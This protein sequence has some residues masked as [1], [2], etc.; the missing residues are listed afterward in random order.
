MNVEMH[1]RIEVIGKESPHLAT[2]EALWRANASTLGF[3]PEGAFIE[4]ATRGNIIGALDDDGKCIGY[5]MFRKTH[6]R[7]TIVHLCVD[8]LYRR[9]GV[10]RELVNHL[11]CLTQD[12]LGIGLTCRRDFEASRLWPE[13]GF[14]ALYDKIGKNRQ[15]INLTFW[16]LDH[17]H[18]TLFTLPQTEQPLSKFR[19]VIDMNIF[20]DLQDHA[21]PGAEESK[22]LQADWL[23]ESLELCMT[24]EVFNEIDRIKDPEERNRRRAMAHMFTIVRCNSQA[25]ESALQSTRRFFPEV[26]S[27]SDK[28]DHRHLA[29][30]VASGEQFFVTR[31][32]DL[33]RIAD[34]LYEAVGISVVSPSEV[35]I[36]LDELLREAEY[37]PARLAGTAFHIGRVCSGQERAMLDVFRCANKRERKSDFS[38]QMRRFLAYPQRFTCLIVSNEQREPVA[39]VVYD[40]GNEHVLEI[41]IIRIRPG[42]LEGTIA[43]HLISRAVTLSSRERRVLTKISDHY[44]SDVIIAALREG[45]FIQANEEW[46]KVNL[47]V[48]EPAARLS[49]R[50]ASLIQIHGLE[51]ECF[52]R[53]MSTLGIH[54]ATMDPQIAAQIEHL[55]WPAKIID[56][57]IP[58][59]VIPI[60]PKWAQHLFDENL[61][62]QTLFGAIPEIALNQEAVYY[63]AVRPSGGLVAPGRILWY[64]SYDRRYPGSGQV[65]ACSRLDEIVIDLPQVLYRRFRRLGVYTWRDVLR[66]VHGRPD[67]V[68]MAIRF[69]NTELFANPIPWQVLQDILQAEGHKSQ[70]QSPLRIPNRIFEKLYVL[71]T[72]VNEG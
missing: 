25:F 17:G 53:L 13:L 54:E 45:G 6:G 30:T 46:I 26:M 57:N 39:L 40:K 5:L 65:R 15:G 50:L 69:S 38:Q 63:R 43:R 16:W 64:V 23:Q 7:V 1:T 68:M 44:S 31:D 27:E 41:P 36:R 52:T 66:G 19:V 10:A 22:S 47:A 28:S 72:R 55:L 4:Y 51:H 33:L 49:E 8:R 21:N 9:K 34:D 61:A 48:A 62:R 58:T 59:F 60:K 42:P 70:I 67:S 29:R 2:V 37:H 12:S 20:L 24:E 32:E 35:V 3:L 71:G 14:V 56:A 11:I 18:P